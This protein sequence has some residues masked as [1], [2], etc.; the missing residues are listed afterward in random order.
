MK[1]EFKPDSMCL[2]TALNYIFRESTMFA[3]CKERKTLETVV[4][5][6]IYYVV[7][8]FLD[9]TLQ[10]LRKQRKQVLSAAFVGENLECL[11]DLALVF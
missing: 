10:G 11:N 3:L 7:L 4:S 8:W 6:A 2:S 5:R 1:M 9:S